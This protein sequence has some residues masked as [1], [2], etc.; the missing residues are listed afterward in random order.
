MNMK[1]IC[2][3][4]AAG[5]LLLAAS[6]ANAQLLGNLKNLG[7]LG[8]VINSVAGTVFSAPVSLDGTYQYGGIAIGLSKSDGNL[9]G[10]VAG[11]A[12]AAGVETKIDEKLAKVGIKPG[13]ATFVFNRDDNSFVCHIMGLSLPGTYK[14]G[15]G[16]KTVTLTFGKKMKYLSM[17]GT[18]ESGLTSAKMLFTA[19]KALTFLKKA[20][21]LAG[22]SSAEIAAITKLADGYDQFKIGFKLT[23]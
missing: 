7:G 18:L 15:E 11:S 10:N 23:K 13:A 12:A 4:F 22:Q 1:K 16:E 14:V 21:S 6:P 20:A 3:L 9:L 5:A 2:T 17:T 19:D 8:N